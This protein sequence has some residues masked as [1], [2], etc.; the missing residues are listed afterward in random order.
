MATEPKI[1]FLDNPHAPEIYVSDATGFFNENG[2]I[3][4]TFEANRIDHS[5]SPG[6]VNR[7]VVGRLAMNI[8][9]AHSLAN[10][11]ANF[12]KVNNLTLPDLAPPPDV[13]KH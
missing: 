1:T 5:A 9:A 13:K 11:L 8:I 10:G 7:V 6:P 4:I 12:L 3:H 2:V